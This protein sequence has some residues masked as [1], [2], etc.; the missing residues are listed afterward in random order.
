MENQ[1]KGEIIMY[2]TEDGLTEIQTTLVDDT[3]WLTA[4]Q[5]AELFCKD[6]TTLRKHFNNV[7]KEGEL[8]RENNTQKMHVVLYPTGQRK[9]PAGLAGG[10][11]V[12]N[13]R[14]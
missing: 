12:H 14:Y 3:V 13:P 11:K 2:Q 7:F 1:S 6:E 4:N 5:M 10:G 8:T 9:S